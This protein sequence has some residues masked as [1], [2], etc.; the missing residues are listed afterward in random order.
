MQILPLESDRLLIRRFN[1]Q[2]L[3]PYLAFML[4][5][6][7]TRYLQF[8]PEQKTEPG[9][10]ALFEY[11]RHCYDFGTPIHAYA[12][13]EQGS[14]RYLGSCG[15]A[16]YSDGIYECYYSVNP[17][18]TGRGVATEALGL[19]TDALARKV[20]VRAYCHPDNPAAHAVAT[21]AGFEARGVIDHQGFAREAALFVFPCCAL[22]G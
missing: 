5:P 18:E 15:Y 21:K 12:I 14:N 2:D 7:S 22:E 6:E 8:D 16:P 17:G 11:V 13:A 1:N 9:A 3:Q 4:N 19:M 20:E 10:R